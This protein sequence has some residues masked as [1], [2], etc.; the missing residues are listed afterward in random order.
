MITDCWV[1]QHDL[2]ELSKSIGRDFTGYLEFK[3]EDGENARITSFCSRCQREQPLFIPKKEI[4]ESFR[5]E[6]A[7]AMVGM[8]S[9]LS[10]KFKHFWF[11]ARCSTCGTDLVLMRS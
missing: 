6:M 11:T 3:P 7:K 1:N 5:H 2:S 4:N 10:P 9:N 8:P